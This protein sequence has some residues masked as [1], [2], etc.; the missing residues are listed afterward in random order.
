V[1][2]ILALIAPSPLQ[3]TLENL[4]KEKK[5]K[6]NKPKKYS[7]LRASVN[8]STSLSIFINLLVTVINLLVTVINLLVTVI[9]LNIVLLLAVIDK[10]NI[11]TYIS[12]LV[13]T[14]RYWNNL[15]QVR[16]WNN[17]YQVRYWNNLYQVRYWNNLHQVHSK[18]K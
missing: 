14:V 9:N 16:Y 12:N 8:N 3:R 7:G 2:P 10:K 6:T 1:G 13:C 18:L 11:K 17:L 4:Y 5:K 15:Y